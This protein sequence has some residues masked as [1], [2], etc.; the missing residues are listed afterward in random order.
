M[1][2][3]RRLGA[4]ACALALW[5]SAE[6]ARAEVSVLVDERGRAY[7]TLFM[8]REGSPPAD[9]WKK[10]RPVDDRLVLNLQGDAWGDG[11]PELAFDPVSGF[12]QVIWAQR[13][14]AATEIVFAH[15][16]GQR[17]TSPA[18]ESGTLAATGLPFSR[19]SALRLS[20]SPGAWSSPRIVIGANRMT[21]AVWSGV[22]FSVP[23]V[24]YHDL[25][26]A[27]GVIGEPFRLNDP[28][29]P[30]SNPS[31]MVGLDRIFVAVEQEEAGLRLVVVVQAEETDTVAQRDSEPFRRRVITIT[32]S[33]GLLDLELFIESGTGRARWLEDPNR[34]GF[35]DYL[36]DIDNW[37]NPW[38]VTT[39]S[40]GSYGL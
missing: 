21:H 24:W 6:I 17:W 38:Y 29:I 28:A 26:L 5:T 13:S 1:R 20:P 34:L 9:V 35:S 2:S 23:N 22:E 14:G 25:S 39:G 33:V 16:D 32:L 31:L 11:M 15:W 37:S 27:G 19:E 4:L 40:S 8:Y 7:G 30:T 10:I 3:A 12:P 18:A 36:A